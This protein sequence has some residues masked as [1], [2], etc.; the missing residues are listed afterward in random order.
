MLDDFIFRALIAGIGVALIAGPMG[1]FVVWRRMAYFGDTMSHTG[2]LGVSLGLIMG[3]APGLGVLMTCLT[4]A[5]LLFFLQKQKQIA[6][7]TLLG[8]LSHATLS[9][10]LVVISFM[11]WV[12]V[13]LMGY[14][15][16]DILAV[17]KMDI[18]WIYLGGAIVLAILFMIWRPLIALT[19]NEPM[20]RAEGMAVTRT[21]IIFMMLVAAVVALSMEVIGILLITSMLIIPAAT[22]RRFAPTP[23]WMAVIAA[24]IGILSV[25]G[26]LYASLTWDTPSGPSVV[27]MATLLFA[28]ALA[29]PVRRSRRGTQ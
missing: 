19:I 7:D 15:F 17:S 8:I 18:L 29:I 26:G 23:E 10:G 25:S 4:V 21:R 16:G 22:A 27:V 11:H 20:A 24:I 1:C 13:D 28:L 2:L 12:R 3:A 9:I 5:L 14:L 6:G